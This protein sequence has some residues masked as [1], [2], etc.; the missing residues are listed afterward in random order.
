MNQGRLNG[1][2]LGREHGMEHTTEYGKDC[3]TESSSNMS[4]YGLRLFKGPCLGQISPFY[5]QIL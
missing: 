4:K 3:N 5:I 2:L 1:R